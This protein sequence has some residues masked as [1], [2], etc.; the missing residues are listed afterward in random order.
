MNELSVEA[1]KI[2]E[3]IRRHRR[4]IHKYAE[5]GFELPQTTKYVMEE[6]KHLGYSPKE[7]CKSGVTATIGDTK[8]RKTFL[9]R[10]DMD[11]LPILEETTLDFK[12]VNGHAH[13][14]GHDMHTA[15][16]LGAAKLL[17]QFEHELKGCVKLM[18][19]PGEE[20]LEGARAMID[21]GVL[22]NPDVDAAMM[23]HV[24]SGMPPKSGTV[25]IGKEGACMASVD[26]F[27]IRVQG[28][29]CHGALPYTGIDPINVLAK[30]HTALQSIN[31]REITYKETI[32]LTVGQIHAGNA[33]NIIPDKG[34][35]EGSLRT[36]NHEI[37]SLVKKRMI[38]IAESIGKAFRAEVKV[39]F[40]Q[41]CDAM[42]NNLEVTKEITR[43]AMEL[44]GEKSV[45][46][47]SSFFPIPGSEDFSLIATA[48]PAV[49]VA[50]SV[51]S[52]DEGY[53]YP[54]HHPKVEF[55][56][57]YLWKGAALYM[58]CAARW[59]QEH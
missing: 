29:G 5:T 49:L 19:Q 27:K 1:Q 2:Q 39:E 31:A 47:K 55:D 42:V 20:I 34:F 32:S 58:N 36:F 16:L 24:S 41:G 17:K 25:L 57:T 7:I 8:R 9:L 26:F 46:G 33:P 3:E 13:A 10:A 37:R 48:V 54:L 51:G 15:M 30:I 56:E 45:E 14:C 28:R 23:I 59:L 12:A 11:A 50:L 38:E 4:V 44:L 52:P 6:L 43:Y 40:S 22:K 18:F 35:L 21:A 53:A